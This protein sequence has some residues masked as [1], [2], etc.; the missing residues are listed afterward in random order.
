MRSAA[1]ESRNGWSTCISP[2]PASSPTVRAASTDS[3]SSTAARKLII[4]FAGLAANLGPLA[5]GDERPPK[6][7]QCVGNAI[8]VSSGEPYLERGKSLPVRGCCPRLR[9]PQVLD[10]LRVQ[11]RLLVGG[12]DVDR[13]VDT[14]AVAE[15]GERGPLS[16]KLG[17]HQPARQ[18]QRLGRLR[19]NG[20]GASENLISAV[21][22]AAGTADEV[23]VI[24][25]RLSTVSL[26]SI[27]RSWMG[28]ARR[29][30]ARGPE[31]A[32]CLYRKRC[33]TRAPNA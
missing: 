23:Q 33:R 13:F 32:G 26:T 11:D 14:D 31:G 20:L 9:R 2:M 8:G 15:L 16:R 5:S 18:D 22:D 21:I 6:V 4:A 24:C 29:Y 30:S 25:R 27:R 12:D 19:R 7:R 28:R 1:S 17:V 3:A 10:A